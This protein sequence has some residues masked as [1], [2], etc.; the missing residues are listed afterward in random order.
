MFLSVKH[1]TKGQQWILTSVP[2]KRKDDTGLPNTILH[3]D[4][5]LEKSQ[6]T[7]CFIKDFLKQ[8]CV[9]IKNYVKIHM[10]RW[11]NSLCNIREW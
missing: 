7:L 9:N 2:I 6:V 1:E 3:L 8:V 4:T 10:V 5:S 11:D